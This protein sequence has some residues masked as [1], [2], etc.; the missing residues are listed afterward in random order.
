MSLW[1]FRS[2]LAIPLLCLRPLLMHEVY[3]RRAHFQAGAEFSVRE[4]AF[5]ARPF[6]AL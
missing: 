4:V 2:D 3:P 1:I 5:D 6:N